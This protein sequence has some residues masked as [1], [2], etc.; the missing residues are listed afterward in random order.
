M[1]TNTTTTNTTTEARAPL[2]LLDFFDTYADPRTRTAT[3][4][5]ADLENAAAHAV[6]LSL[7]AKHRASANPHLADLQNAYAQDRRAANAPAIAE[8]LAELE[9]ERAEILAEDSPY[10]EARRL[11]D[12]AARQADRLTITPAERVE[13]A[14]KAAEAARLVE[15]YTRRL[16]RITEEARNLAAALDETYT[17]RA[18]LVQTAAA[19]ILE[20]L[21]HTEIDRATLAAYGADTAADLDPAERAA[22]LAETRRKRVFKAIS[23]EIAAHSALN[24]HNAHRTD[25]LEPI[26]A[27][28]VAQIKAGAATITYG[29]RAYAWTLTDYHHAARGEYRA[30][31]GGGQYLA[32]EWRDTKKPRRLGWYVVK[33]R[34]TVRDISRL[35]AYTDDDGEQIDITP[36]TAD[37]SAWQTA[38][39]ADRLQD[40]FDRADLTKRDRDFFRAWQSPAAQIAA[41]RARRAAGRSG[42]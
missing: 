37:F 25:I 8:A 29:G 23:A 7:R 10:T 2:T 14:K 38:T 21:T 31:L 33:H 30:D 6:Y 12:H 32:F 1:K 40:L 9:T 20:A 11:R 27:D 17:D 26:P 15:A 3:D 24:T 13:W 22:A 28:I 39:A 41:A 35:E 42:A 19:A 5:A 16:A 34:L 4:Y 18:D 36:Q